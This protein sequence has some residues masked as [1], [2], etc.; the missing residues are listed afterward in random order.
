MILFFYFQ[1]VHLRSWFIG[2][3]ELPIPNFLLIFYT[4]KISRVR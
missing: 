4:I 2:E 1:V 3:R